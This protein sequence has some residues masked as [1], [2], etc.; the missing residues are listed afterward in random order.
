MMPASILADSVSYVVHVM[1]LLVL[2]V[3]I[4]HGLLIPT[5]WLF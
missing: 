2:V 5:V 4:W 1:Q 3:P